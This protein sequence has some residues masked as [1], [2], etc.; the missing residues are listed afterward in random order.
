MT[1]R[2]LLIVTA[3][4]AVG[5]SSSADA[6][7]TAMNNAYADILGPG[8]WYSANYERMLVDSLGV[9]LGFAYMS[10]GASASSG[11][12]EASS[13]VSFLMFP[14]TAS[15]IGLG[16]RSHSL[17]LGGG[18][19]LY[20]LTA[21]AA[22][23][24]GSPEAEGAHAF[25]NFMV[26]Y[27]LH[28]EHGG[29]TFRIGFCGLLGTGFGLDPED[30]TALGMFP[31]GY[32]S[33]GYAWGTREPADP[34]DSLSD[35]LGDS[36]SSGLDNLS[37][38]DNLPD[39]DLGGYDGDD[40]GGGLDSPALDEPDDAPA[41]LLPPALD[42]T[43][44]T[45]T[46]RPGRTR[47]AKLLRAFGKPSR[48]MKKPGADVLVYGKK[49]FHGYSQVHFYVRAGG[50]VKHVELFPSDVIRPAQLRKAYGNQFSSKMAGGHKRITYEKLGLVFFLSKDGR[51]VVAVRVE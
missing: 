22:S 37:D 5:L 16:S 4:L 14:V 45:R 9:R 25:G 26:G 8:G 27:R 32:L 47:Q 18:A 42:P 3:A 10:L 38:G 34:S 50:V 23:F 40:A 41:G 1:F 21:R 20:Y 19:T 35:P 28:P 12:S 29:F 7:R 51:R 31:S 6:R 39:N 36:S 30:P 11:G 24:G 48:E 44:P 49:L 13:K 15:F 2:R 33:F 17:E 46:V 43:E